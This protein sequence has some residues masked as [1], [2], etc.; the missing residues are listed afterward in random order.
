MK[1]IVR[2]TIKI[3][4]TSILVLGVAF[5]IWFMSGEGVKEPGEITWGVTFFPKQA[6]DLGLEWQNVYIELLD[7][8]QVKNLRLAVPW[9][10]VE[11]DQGKYDFS[12]IDWMIQEA[13]KRDA[14]I[15]LAVGRKLFRWPECHDPQWIYEY[16]QE[17]VNEMTLNFVRDSVEHFKKYDNI[18]AWQVENEPGFPFG[19]CHEDPPN[20]DLFKQEVEIVRELDSRP[21]I[22]TDSGELASWLSFSSHVD[23]L[24]VSLYRITENP[25][26]GRF[27]YPMR[28]GFYQKKS[29]IVQA[30]NKN[31][32]KVFLSEL[33]L[34]PWSIVPMS[35]MTLSQQFDS[36][37][38]KRTQATIDY[39]KRTGFDEI[40]LWGVEWWYWLRQEHKDDRFWNL[41][42]TLMP[43]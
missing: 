8:M 22:S 39:A 4:V 17:A 1:K 9:N 30:I 6:T 37:N 43:D 20:K 2:R 42:K 7:D 28:P 5:A 27:Y 18:I 11:M 38:F 33:Q 36:M 26:W 35:E 13:D 40:Y 16:K 14:K 24:G 12:E 31:V 19:E 25:I 3:T 34:E 21:I 23:K 10:V 41:G 29:S 15:L 32:E